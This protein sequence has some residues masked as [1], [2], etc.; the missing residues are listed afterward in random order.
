MQ[1]REQRSLRGLRSMQPFINNNVSKS[2]RGMRSIVCKTKPKDPT[3][4]KDS[5]TEGSSSSSNSSVGSLEFN[6]DSMVDI[7]E[8]TT[9]VNRKKKKKGSKTKQHKST[10]IDSHRANPLSPKVARENLKSKSTQAI[11]PFKNSGQPKPPMT[12]VRVK[13]KKTTTSQEAKASPNNSQ[14]AYP[15]SPKAARESQKSKNTQS[16]KFSKNADQQAPPVKEVIKKIKRS[17]EVK[18]P[19]NDLP[20][21]DHPSPHVS[22]EKLKNKSSQQAESSKHVSFAEHPT[23]EVSQEHQTENQSSQGTKSFRTDSQP[24]PSLPCHLDAIAAGASISLQSHEVRAS[25]DDKIRMAVEKYYSKL[26][27]VRRKQ[28]D[29]RDYLFDDALSTSVDGDTLSFDEATGEWSRMVDIDDIIE[30]DE[31]KRAT[32]GDDMASIDDSSMNTAISREEKWG[33]GILDSVLLLC[34]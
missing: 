24:A 22:R 31:L 27:A 25:S 18:P 15:L 13:T 12:E 29:E 9:R 2:L 7:R 19:P 30:D 5:Y 33:T 28:E 34:V 20:C 14:R 6:L 23:P 16:I 21:V 11:N 26:E 10:R 3:S 4:D 1:L 32:L 8:P 17:Q